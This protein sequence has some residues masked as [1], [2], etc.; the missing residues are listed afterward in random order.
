MQT[1]RN[2]L[3]A[4][5]A[6]SLSWCCAYPVS[7]YAQGRAYPAKPVTLVVAFAAGNASDTVARLVAQQLSGF[8]GQQVVVENRPGAGGVGAVNQVAN[9]TPDGYTLLYIGVGMAISQALFKPQP[10]DMQKSFAPVSTLSSNDVLFLVRKDSRLARIDDFIREAREKKG[11]LMVGVAL[12]GTT[13][14]LGAE[15]FKA[16]GK[17]DYTIVPF[18]SAGAVT[19]AL[20]AG[21]IDLA[22]EFVP[23]ALGS[24]R[25]GQ[26]RALAISNAKRSDVLPDIPTI[27]ELGIPNFDVSS[28]SMIVAPVLTPDAIVQRLNREMQ[29]ALAQPEVALRMKEAGVRVLGGTVTQA[30]EL[31]ASELI[32]WSN[33]INESKITM[34]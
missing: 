30:R 21:D 18:K 9:A 17:V 11:G 4:L 19:T 13:Q 20:S 26:L 33:V 2:V 7:G 27:A 31:M 32:K 15:L 24:V 29:R 1:K 16:R 23:P 6:L 10:Y 5:A 34:K 3:S 22:L 25:S 8:L 14:H 12:L 28:W